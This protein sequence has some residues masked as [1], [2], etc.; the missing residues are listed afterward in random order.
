MND[1]DRNN[2]NQKVLKD[3]FKK[4]RNIKREESPKWKAR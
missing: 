4:K 1:V 3:D 2:I